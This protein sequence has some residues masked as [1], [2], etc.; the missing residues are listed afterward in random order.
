MFIEVNISILI[1][2]FFSSH[3]QYSIISRFNYICIKKIIKIYNFF[4][5]KYTTIHQYLIAASASCMAIILHSFY[6][7][8]FHRSLVRRLSI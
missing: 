7:M 6:I 3:T 5:T 2:N 4:Y 1:Y 8:S